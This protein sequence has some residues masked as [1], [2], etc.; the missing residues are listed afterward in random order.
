VSF[1]PSWN[2]AQPEI[3]D[4]IVQHDPVTLQRIP[5]RKQGVIDIFTKFGNSKALRA[6]EALPAR[7]GWLDDKEI[8][9]LLLT[10]HWEM[11]RLAE[12]FFH[13]HRV[14]EVLKELV[15]AIRSTGFRETLR[16]ADVGCGIGY[17]PRWLAAR[18]PLAEHNIEVIGIDLNS[19]LISEAKRLAAEER[20]PCQFV[21][22]DAFS[23]E[24][25]NHIYI[26]T[27]VVH[28]FRGDGLAE[29]LERHERPET[30]GFL[31]FDFQPWILAPV[32][33][34]FFHNLRM[35]TAIARHDGVL[36]A[37][38]AYD[39]RTLVGAA[40]TAA[41]GFVAGIYG[42]KI[43]GTPA[44]RVFHTLTGVRRELGSQFRRQ[45]GRHAGRLGELA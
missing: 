21:H 17:T 19:T 38:R 12:E 33:S 41:P 25:S 35:R 5:V 15:A 13:G 4:L 44:P 31:H 29:F 43:W 14:W 8:D 20:L 1:F 34:L 45:L 40:R 32:G 42:A 24:H 7:D 27:C 2:P 30:K 26:S 11:Q 39:A 22:G 28:H 18:V 9:A 10:V 3:T 36:S 23:G 37:A 16:I 6:V